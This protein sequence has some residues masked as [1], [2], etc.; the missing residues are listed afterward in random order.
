[1]F[2]VD[3][4]PE[5]GNDQHHQNDQQRYHQFCS[6]IISLDLNMVCKNRVVF[7]FP[8]FAEDYLPVVA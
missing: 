2:A 3:K 4:L 1:M 7:G 5:G 8:Q 6:H